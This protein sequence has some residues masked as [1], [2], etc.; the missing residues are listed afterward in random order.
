MT[1]GYAGGVCACCGCLQ[2][3]RVLRRI[4]PLLHR[5]QLLLT[6][7]QGLWRKLLLVPPVLSL[8]A[9]N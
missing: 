9:R 5:H 4:V 7:R 3:L 2:S 8:T 6:P 1:S